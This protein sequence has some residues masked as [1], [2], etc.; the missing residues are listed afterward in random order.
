M[1]VQW[2]PYMAISKP[3]RGDLIG[4]ANA[5]VYVSCRVLPMGWISACGVLQHVHRQLLSAIPR[6]LEPSAEIRSDAAFPDVG[7]QALRTLWQVYIDNVDVLEVCR[8]SQVAD[9]VG[10]LADSV[11]EALSLYKDSG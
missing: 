2:R 9:L 10:T 7:A 3:I 11:R 8:T 4:H 1:P 6:S 5:T